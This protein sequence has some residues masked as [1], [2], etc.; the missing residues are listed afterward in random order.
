MHGCNPAKIPH[1]IFHT[2]VI[3]KTGGG[4]GG[5]GGGGL[6][7]PKVANLSSQIQMAD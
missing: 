7:D 6:V 3:D 2:I 1:A 5:R 4:G